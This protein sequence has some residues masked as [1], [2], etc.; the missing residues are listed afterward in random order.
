[1][2]VVKLFLSVICLFAVTFAFAQKSGVIEKNI[3]NSYIKVQY[4]AHTES[5]QSY[6]SLEKAN[7]NLGNLIKTYAIKYPSTITAP[8]K[9]LPA[10]LTVST[11]ADGLFRIYSWDRLTGGTMHFFANV[12]Q[13]KIGDKTY[14]LLDQPLGE[15]VNGPFYHKLFTLKAENKTY[16]LAVFLVIGSS[17]DHLRGLQVFS[18]ENGKLNANTKLIKTKS[19]LHNFLSYEYDVPDDVDRDVDVS[20]HYD[21]VTQT[22]KFP[23]IASDGKFTTKFITYKFNGQYFEK[24]ILA[25]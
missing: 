18:I 10:G 5:E 1:M 20:I 6:D 12:F 24:V 9:S 4:W 3:F 22:I 8:F 25:K 13:Y 21:N 2:K 7:D 19:G 16:Y 11:A 23:L 14:A 15:G 17:R